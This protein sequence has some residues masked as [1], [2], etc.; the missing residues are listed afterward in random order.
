MTHRARSAAPLLVA[1]AAIGLTACTQAPAT[2]QGERVAWLYSV[3]LVAAAVVFVVVSGLIG[4]SILRYRGRPEDGLPPQT[5]GSVVLELIWWAIPT[6]LVILLFILTAGVL[7][8]VNEQADEPAVTVDVEGFQWG[9]RF[10]Y[11]DSGVE[12]VGSAEQDP[13]EVYLPVGE[14]IAF[15]LNSPDVI[16]SFWVPAFLIKRDVNPGFE[17]RLDVVIPEAGRYTGQCAEFCGLLHD[18]MLF[19]IVAVDGAEF[20]R[21]LAEQQ[22]DR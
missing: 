12:V 20:D 4:W 6:A 11:R 10:S 8:T 13:P 7:N 19:T 16:H 5:H 15:T 9:W 21:W 22:E 3:F 18:R 1:A 17:N 14:P 2:A